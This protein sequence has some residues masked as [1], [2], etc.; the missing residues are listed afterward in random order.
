MGA[1]DP[2]MEQSERARLV[3]NE[4]DSALASAL[5]NF[6]DVRADEFFS[7]DDVRIEARVIALLDDVL[8]NWA[9]IAPYILDA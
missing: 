3:G 9:H 8:D 6:D 1:F 5:D 7:A 2:E 4:L